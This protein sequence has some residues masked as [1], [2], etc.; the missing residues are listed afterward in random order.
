MGYM[1]TVKQYLASLQKEYQSALSD[2]QHTA[3][4]SYRPILD[5]FFR[6]LAKDLTD[7]GSVEVVLEPRSQA[8]IGR[9]DWRMHDRTSLGVYGYVEAK[10]LSDQPFDMVPYQT[11]IK[12]YLSL[13]HKLILTD[14]IE[15]I[16]CMKKG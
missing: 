11:Q 5:T 3:E 13:Q 4:L 10:G 7:K 14:G 2:R 8:K 15:F 6:S 12:R 9:P 1:H 16:F